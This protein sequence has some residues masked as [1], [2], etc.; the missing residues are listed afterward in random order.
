MYLKEKK[1]KKEKQEKEKKKERKQKKKKRKK[2]LFFDFDRSD[3]FNH[4]EPHEESKAKLST[5]AKRSRSTFRV[6]IINR[7]DKFTEFY[8]S[9]TQRCYKVLTRC[10]ECIYVYDVSV[11]VIKGEIKVYRPYAENLI[12]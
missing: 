9:H 11:Y 6:P 4:C 5:S 12:S 10:I 8:S 7:D 2:D 1:R 3:I